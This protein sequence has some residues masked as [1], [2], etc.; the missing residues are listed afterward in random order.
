M[1]CEEFLR[2]TALFN[3]I[4][5]AFQRAKIY[6][7]GCNNTAKDNL[8]RDLERFLRE[9]EGNYRRTVSSANHIRTIIDIA[10][11]LSKRHS[12]ILQGGQ[13]RVGIA[14]KAINIY[15]KLLWCY[16]WIPEPP[17]CPI[18]SIVLAEIGDRKTRWTQMDDIAV[19][20]TTIDA[21]RKHIQQKGKTQ[22][23]P[24]WELD[25]WNK[26]KKQGNRQ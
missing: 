25:V 3:A 14:Q 5:A 13:F 9:I 4:G 12:M 21:I 19:Y 20:R 22:S 26:R 6:V 2:Q 11:S 8:K 18:D 23:L 1:Q 7:D 17:H 10:K 24:Q 16:R 15:L